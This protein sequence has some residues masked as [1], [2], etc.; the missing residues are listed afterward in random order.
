MNPFSQSLSG[1]KW[2]VP[3]SLL[4]VVLGFMMTAAWVT[5]ENR[6]GRLQLAGPGQGSRVGMG[7]IDIQEK[8][9]EVSQEV[10]KLRSEKTTMERALGDKN[11]SSKVLN[12]ELQDA[13]TQ[14]CLTEIEGP[15]LTVTLKDSVKPVQGFGQDQAIHDF[16]LLRVVNELW[17]AGAEAIA[18]NGHRVAVGTSFRCVG[19][20]IMVDN[21]RVAPPIMV[22]AIGDAQTLNGALN[23]P[24]G[25][26]SEIRSSDP[27]MVV[28]EIVSKMRLPAYTG[29]TTR[30]YGIVP[31]DAK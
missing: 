14:A 25:V 13:K 28:V 15:G 4:S 1:N 2:V 7:T 10:A 18:V 6:H 27:S 23:I 20:V 31:K 5:N 26:L 24:L 21:I 17:N 9:D 19:S 29:S 3:V 16:D 12:D 22:R 30:K 8:Y 11:G